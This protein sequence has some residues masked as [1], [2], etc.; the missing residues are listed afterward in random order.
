MLDEKELKLFARRNKFENIKDQFNGDIE[1]DPEFVREALDDVCVRDALLHY[2]SD[3]YQ[4]SLFGKDECTLEDCSDNRKAMAVFLTATCA[5]AGA[6]GHIVAT[7]AGIALLDK[8]IEATEYLV[9]EVLENDPVRL[10]HL[11]RYAL[12]LS[13][14]DSNFDIFRNWKDSVEEND[15]ETALLGVNN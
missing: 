15:I 13:E 1:F 11:L 12:D 7:L 6:T 5:V 9:K 14:K 2:V 3:K 10:A 4:I 8:E